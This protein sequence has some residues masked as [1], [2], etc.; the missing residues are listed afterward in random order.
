MNIIVQLNAINLIE[1]SSQ[2]KTSESSITKLD[3]DI[4]L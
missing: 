1:P 4:I 3:L 2:S